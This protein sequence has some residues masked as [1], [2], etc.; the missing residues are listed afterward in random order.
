MA[1]KKKHGRKI[2]AGEGTNLYPTMS[3]KRIA[4]DNMKSTMLTMTALEGIINLGKY[5]FVINFSFS[6]KELLLSVSAFEKNCHG[7][8]AAYTKIGYGTPSE[9]NLAN[10]PNITVNTIIVSK[11]LIIPQAIPITVCLYLTK[12]SRQAKK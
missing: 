7:N 1:K 4:N 2:V 3:N 9:G 8:I 5:T 11:G 12:I 10:F 6:I